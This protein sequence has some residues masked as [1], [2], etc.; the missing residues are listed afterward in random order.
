MQAQLA[1]RQRKSDEA[2]QDWVR[3]TRD[4]AYVEVRLDDR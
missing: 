4:R 1:I 2:F 3:Q